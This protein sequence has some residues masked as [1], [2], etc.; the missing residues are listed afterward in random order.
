MFPSNYF[1]KRC[2]LAFII[3]RKNCITS[4]E[5]FFPQSE[6]NVICVSTEHGLGKT[7]VQNN[8]CIL[9]QYKP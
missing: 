8:E 4:L 2:V 6:K 5:I 9:P 7:D 1:Q 3:A